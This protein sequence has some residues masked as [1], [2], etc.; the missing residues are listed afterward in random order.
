MRY[1]WTDSW[2]DAAARQNPLRWG[3]S[4]SLLSLRHELESQRESRPLRIHAD[5]HD[6]HIERQF[7]DISS[8]LEWLQNEFSCEEVARPPLP[9]VETFVEPAGMPE[10]ETSRQ[11]LAPN[12]SRACHGAQVPTLRYMWADAGLFARKSL[13]NL[14]HRNPLRWSDA[15]SPQ[16]MVKSLEQA[17]LYYND[18]PV[19]LE[20]ESRDEHTL[21]TFSTMQEAIDWIRTA[22]NIHDEAS[23]DE[24]HRC[25]ICL[26]SEVA[27]M[28]MPCRHAVLCDGCAEDLFASRASLQSCPICRTPITNHARGHFAT[29]Y[30][31]LVQAMDARMERTS[32]SMYEGMYN[33]VRP[34]MLTGALLGTGAAVCFVVAPPVAPALA[35]AAFVIGYVPWFATTSAHFER[36]DLQVQSQSFFSR[37]DLSNPLKLITKVVVMAVVAPVAAIGFFVPYGI[38]R[39][40]LKPVSRALLQGLVRLSAFAQVYALR[41]TAQALQRVGEGILE[42]LRLV[43]GHARDLAFM[44][45][46]MLAAAGTKAL[47]LATAI[48]RFLHEYALTPC[49]RG[50][51]YC[52]ELVADGSRVAYDN[53]ILPAGRAIRMG[54]AFL[55]TTTHDRAIVP[56]GRAMRRLAESIGE[57]MMQGADLIGQG[58]AII[59]EYVLTPC[60]RFVMLVV[61]STLARAQDVYSYFLIPCG[62]AAFAALRMMARGLLSGTEFVF[63]NLLIPLGRGTLSAL[64]ILGKGVVSGA[65]FLYRDAVVP[66]G[67]TVATILRGIA[68]GLILGATTTYTCVLK[69]CGEGLAAAASQVYSSALLPAAGAIYVYALAPSGRALHSLG[70]FLA[71]SASAAAASIAQC[72]ANGAQ[73]VYAYVLLPGGQVVVLVTSIVA[74]AAQACGREVSVAIDAAGSA[75]QQACLQTRE[76]LSNIRF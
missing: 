24:P 74:G 18:R 7:R 23:I 52:G 29:D 48:S 37:D 44:L 63:S 10:C 32:A 25:V 39:G 19:K 8:A 20:V 68:N 72:A 33:H 43:G 69:P 60:G 14:A 55:A 64:R 75:M 54:I 3:R 1:M 38:Y 30:V 40:V 45:G 71:A 5:L 65:E 9:H 50:A 67:C 41:P 61:R 36:E 70:V 76:V 6:G 26:E 27:V 2:C 16:E 58:T 59:Y 4:H 22:Y 73:A 66:L 62:R 47:E 53:A 49:V 11:P 21:K 34:L 31:D 12:A 17:E 56:M 57:L 42:L 28:L 35:G 51:Q 13:H 15:K 46:D